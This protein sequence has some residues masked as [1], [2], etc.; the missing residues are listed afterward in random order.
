MSG[1]PPPP[2]NA[3]DNAAKRSFQ[4]HRRIYNVFQPGLVR[5]AARLAHDP[6]KR[7]AYVEHPTEGWRVYL[8]SAAF[9]HEEGDRRRNRFIVVKKT[10]ADPRARTWEPPKGQMEGKDAGLRSQ[11]IPPLMQVLK[12]NVSREVEEE[13]AIHDLKNL[14]H[15]G[16]VFQ[17]REFDFPENWVFQYHIFS[18]EATPETIQE[19]RDHFQWARDHPAAFARFKR[20]RREKDDITWFNPRETALYGRWSGGLVA[21]YLAGKP[22]RY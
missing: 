21:L 2:V 20:D 6:A 11:R 17:Q 15:T 18:A 13:A 12:Q 8:R 10:G 5:G 14:R 22:T 4:S 1:T 19:A 3:A 16:I 7:Y 9:I